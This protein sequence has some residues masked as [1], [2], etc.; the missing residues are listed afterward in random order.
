[1]PP[2]HL[3]LVSTLIIFTLLSDW[4]E[5]NLEEDV[6][7][8]RVVIR[9][10][11][12]NTNEFSNSIISL[13]DSSGEQVGS[14]QV[15]G[16]SGV[17]LI[18][19]R[20]S[21]F[22]GIPNGYDPPLSGSCKKYGQDYNSFYEEDMYTEVIQGPQVCADYCSSFSSVPGFV[23]MSTHFVTRRCTCHFDAHVLPSSI[24]IPSNAT[25]VFGQG[26]VGRPN[27]GAYYDDGECYA[28]TV[29]CVYVM[30]LL[31]IILLI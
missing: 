29:C 3:I 8:E 23:A 5:L 16:T 1:M 11:R 19:L 30:R 21:F 24:D 2:L 6:G 28:F 4:W 26:A 22:W 9:P 20:A 31:L 12:Y 7:V 14:Y 13:F 15:G 25:S 27:Y 10:R 17:Q 18:T